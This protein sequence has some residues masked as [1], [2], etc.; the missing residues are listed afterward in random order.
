M[1]KILIRNLKPIEYVEFDLKQVNLFI[2][3][4]SS[5]KS[6][7]LKVACFCRWLEKHIYNSG[8]CQLKD[9]NFKNKLCTFARMS[10]I[11]FSDDT[12]IIYEGDLLVLHYSGK[13]VTHEIKHK[14]TYQ[15]NKLAYIPSERSLVSAIPRLRVFYKSRAYDNILNYIEEWTEVRESYQKRFKIQKLDIDYQY[16]KE[17]DRDH[18]FLNNGE[19]IPLSLT[20]SGYQ[21]VV[22][23]YIQLNYYTDTMFTQGL[24][25]PTV[26]EKEYFM[27]KYAQ[28]PDL[29][30][31]E[32]TFEQ[33][34]KEKRE[35]TY[36]QLFIEEPEQN[37]F[38]TTQANLVDDIVKG[39][40]GNGRENYLFMSTHSP[41][42]LTRL[43][44]LIE[45]A[46]ASKMYQ[47][48]VRNLISDDYLLP[49]DKV[50]AFYVDNGKVES[51]MNKEYK[52]IRSDEIDRIS[53]DI[54][55]FHYQLEDMKD[56]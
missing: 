4:Q 10:D 9:M 56:E 45:A 19:E 36:S 28:E 13:K 40:T 26:N 11:A 53:E 55:D 33:Y 44:N 48:K 54:N 30:K 15:N 43:N 47:D 12:E 17:W 3:P 51:I 24:G 31:K 21:S 8:V 27:N 35:Y 20:P 18:V 5:G 41:Y 25:Q 34:L 6:T 46:E 14:S 2:G 22:P 38:P 16:D 32:K 23:L 1:A 49:Y 50:N 52:M 42:I 29:L 7:I 37:L 39:I